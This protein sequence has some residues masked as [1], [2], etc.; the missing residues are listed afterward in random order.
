MGRKARNT[1]RGSRV[2]KE[3]R[4]RASLYEVC[5][6]S[7]AT[8]PALSLSS[9]ARTHSLCARELQRRWRRYQHAQQMGDQAPAAAAAKDRRGGHNRAFT[10]DQ[11]ELLRELCLAAS[12]AMTQ[13]ELQQAALQ[14]K[15]DVVVTSSRSIREPRRVQAFVASPRSSPSSSD[16]IDSPRIVAHSTTSHS[17]HQIRS[18][19]STPF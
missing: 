14:L 13:N 16:A 5:L 1:E 12:P 17:P 18:S 3:K 9:I 8:H 15:R 4:K 19:A 10:D 11:E 2:A 7:K 6:V